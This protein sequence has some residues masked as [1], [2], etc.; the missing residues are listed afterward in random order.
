[1]CSKL[2][3]K[4][5]NS[6]LLLSISH[7]VKLYKVVHADGAVV[8]DGCEPSANIREIKK[9]PKGAVLKAMD[10]QINSANVM[11][12]RL[13]DESNGWVSLLDI[14]GTP[15]LEEIANPEVRT[16]LTLMYWK[17]LLTQ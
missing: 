8:Q 5:G 16:S 14:T 15:V 4:D 3:F 17:K 12:I 9:V 2:S 6:P 11:N 7:R 1:M 10:H 13:A